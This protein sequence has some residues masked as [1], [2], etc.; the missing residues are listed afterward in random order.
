MVAGCFSYNIHR[1]AFTL[2]NALNIGNILG[3]NHHSHAFLALI[4]DDFLCRQS[5]VADREGIEIDMS[6]CLLN[7]FGERV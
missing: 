5:F 2:G 4:A 6:A 7:Q 3:I 1:R